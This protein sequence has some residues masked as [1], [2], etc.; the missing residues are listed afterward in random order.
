MNAKAN[1]PKVPSALEV[2]TARVKHLEDKIEAL[3][4]L[5]NPV[6]FNGRAIGRCHCG[7][8]VTKTVVVDHQIHGT[9]SQGVCDE[10]PANGYV[11]VLAETVLPGRVSIRLEQDPK[12]LEFIHRINSSLSFRQ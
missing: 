12:V 1:G 11:A 4:V 8:L 7:K 5:Q 6:T 2:L 10:C 3:Y 9:H